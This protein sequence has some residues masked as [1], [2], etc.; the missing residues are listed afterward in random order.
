MR[1][2]ECTAEVVGFRRQVHQRPCR[3][4][5]LHANLTSPWSENADAIDRTGSALVL[6]DA[7]HDAASIHNA[8]VLLLT[9]GR[10]RWSGAGE[11]FGEQRERGGVAR[12]DEVKIAAVHGGEIGHV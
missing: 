9:D 10:S 5:A 11:A 7:H 1:V 8:I 12:P 6:D 4:R 3:R 2:S